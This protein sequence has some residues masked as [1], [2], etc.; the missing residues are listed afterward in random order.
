MCRD[1]RWAAVKNKTEISRAQRCRNLRYKRPALAGMG[2]REIMIGIEE[3]QEVCGEIHWAF[4]DDETLVNAFDGNEEEAYEFRMAFIELESQA[5]ALENSINDTLG[6]SEDAQ[7]DFDDCGVALVGNRFNVV[8]YDGWEEDYF[9]LCSFESDLA[10]TD[11]GKRIMRKTKAE[12]IA[13]I[14][15]TVGIIMSWLNIEYRYEY[16]KAT[17]DIFRDENMSV[18]QAIKDIE[19]KYSEVF[20]GEYVDW[21]AEAEFERMVA[22]LPDR[23]W[24]E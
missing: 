8:G 21:K 2:Y 22:E 3:M 17:I 23:Y 14:G 16:L 19:K 20:D 12:I 1:G 5:Y 15:Q 9:S 18:L 13:T 11:S 7:R 10:W 24:C 6:W 4:D